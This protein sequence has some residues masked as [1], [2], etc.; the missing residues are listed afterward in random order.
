MR[1]NRFLSFRPGE[2]G[3]A[4]EGMPVSDADDEGRSAVWKD[5]DSI[6]LK[7]IPAVGRQPMFNGW[8]STCCFFWKI[9]IC[10]LHVPFGVVFNFQHDLNKNPFGGFK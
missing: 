8:N 4:N 6:P 10:E 7:P 5:S 9:R 2:D 3:G 1:L